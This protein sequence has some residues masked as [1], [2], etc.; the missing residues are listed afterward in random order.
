MGRQGLF[1]ASSSGEPSLHWFWRQNCRMMS[2]SQMHMK[3]ARR[4]TVVSG[5]EGRERPEAESVAR[6][7]KMVPGMI[8]S[9]N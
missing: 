6:R 4:R 7:E 1:M 5:R 3:G 9:K 8:V 2:Q